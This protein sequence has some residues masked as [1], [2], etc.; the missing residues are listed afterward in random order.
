MRDPLPRYTKQLMEMGV[1]TEADINK[2][3]TEVEAEI[4]AAFEEANSLPRPGGYE[5]LKKTA[6]AEL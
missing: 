6:V 5:A 3:E 2:L 1:L 4:E